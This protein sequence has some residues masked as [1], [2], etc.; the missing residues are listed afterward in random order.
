MREMRT[1]PGACR[2]SGIAGAMLSR[3]HDRS[4]RNQRAALPAG[5]PSITPAVS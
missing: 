4:L 5:Q 3:R 2:C 1:S